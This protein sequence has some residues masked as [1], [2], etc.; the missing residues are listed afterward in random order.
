MV[1]QPGML[2]FSTWVAAYGLWGLALAAFLAATLLPMSSEVAVVAALHLG[3]PASTVLLWA[4]AGNC[5]GAMTNYWLGLLCTKPVLAQ[6]QRERWGRQ[7]L[8]WA[9]RYGG[10]SLAAS[11]LPLIGDPILLVA[12]I[13]RCHLGYVILLG[14]GTRVARYT[15]LIGLLDR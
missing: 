5:L 8:A 11:C 3:L 6:V 10:W 15:L 2:D 14:L 7:A 4:S 12:G 9:E 13:L 1:W